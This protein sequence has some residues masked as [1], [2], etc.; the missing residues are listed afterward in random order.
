MV[1]E[2]AKQLHKLLKQDIHA[3]TA[4]IPWSDLQRFF[5]A[6][7]AIHV[8]LKLDLVDV[9]LQMSTDNSAQVRQWMDSG[10]IATVSDDLARHWIDSDA[11]VWAVVVKPWVLVQEVQEQHNAH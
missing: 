1:D 4:K 8:A 6:G 3:E 9:A 7:K 2:T 5:A 11:T 10:E